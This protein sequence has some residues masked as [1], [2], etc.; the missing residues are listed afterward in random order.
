M[1]CDEAKRL[2]LQ[3]NTLMSN[4]LFSLLIVSRVNSLNIRKVRK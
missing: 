4:H 1:L 3:R 2:K